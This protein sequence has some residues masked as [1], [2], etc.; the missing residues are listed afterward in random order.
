MEDKYKPLSEEQ[1]T[2]LRAVLEKV[3]SHLPEAEA[4][5]IWQM[6]NAVRDAREPQPCTCASSGAHWGRAIS[7]LR[8]WMRERGENF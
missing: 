7:E 1:V 2:K 4:P 5:F 8:L 6:F 3:T